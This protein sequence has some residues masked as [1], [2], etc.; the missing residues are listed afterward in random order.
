MRKER[1]PEG[2]N[3]HAY[4]RVGPKVLRLVSGEGGEGRLILTEASMATVQTR[5]PPRP[6]AGRDHVP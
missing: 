1:A 4:R 3:A 2:R 5:G 6:E